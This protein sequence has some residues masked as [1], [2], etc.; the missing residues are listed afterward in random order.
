MVR[1]RLFQPFPTAQLVAALPPTAR[2]IAVLDRCKEP[3][4]VGE[5]LYLEVLAALTEATD[6]AEPP[7]AAMPQ[8]IGGRYGLSSKELTPSMVEPIFAELAADRPRRHFTVG[9]Y[10]DV[11]NLS[12]PING[13]FRPP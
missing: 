5:P 1:L 8:V 13:E 4:A 9:I 10:D 2:R 11:T 6:V 12:L 3:G 7:F